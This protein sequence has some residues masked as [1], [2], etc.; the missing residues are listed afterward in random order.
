MTPALTHRLPLSL[1]P[2]HLNLLIH[3]RLASTTSSGS[4]LSF[5]SH[6]H[7]TPHQIFHLP[8]GASQQ[9]IKARYYDLVRTHH[10][11]SPNVRTLPPPVRRAHFQA[12]TAA[13]DALRGKSTAS[14][15]WGAHRDS[16][17]AEELARRRRAHSSNYRRPGYAAYGPAEGFPASGVEEG[18]KDKVII[19]TGL[20]AVIG[21]LAP[22][23]FIPTVEKDRRHREAAANLAQARREAVEVG[24]ERRRAMKQ[25][26]AEHEAWKRDAEEE[27][28]RL[29]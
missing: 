21:S 6:S 3:A 9:Q 28:R 23:L 1:L 10:P 4:D 27:R 16:V 13:Y 29:V 24:V 12:I 17:Y 2:A 7:P 26:V 25:R 20:C 14:D 19:L 22:F 11:D 8:P 18:W 15:S 5:P